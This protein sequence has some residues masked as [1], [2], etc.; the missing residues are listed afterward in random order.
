MFTGAAARIKSAFCGSGNEFGRRMAARVLAQVLK[1][2]RQRA[3]A[4]GQR[5][6]P[7]MD[8]IEDR[9]VLAHHL[10]FEFGYRAQKRRGRSVV[11]F[12]LARRHDREH[13]RLSRTWQTEWRHR[14]EPAPLDGAALIE[15]VGAEDSDAILDRLAFRV[16]PLEI[17]Q[18]RMI[19]PFDFVVRIVL[20][21]GH[22]VQRLDVLHVGRV[23]TNHPRIGRRDLRK[24][25]RGHHEFGVGIR[26]VRDLEAWMLTVVREH[27]AVFFANGKFE[28][29]RGGRRRIADLGR[30][31]Y[32]IA[33]VAPMMKGAS[34]RIALNVADRE[35]RADMRAVCAH[36]ARLAAYASIRDHAPIEEIDAENFPLR[37]LARKTNRE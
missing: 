34:D 35:I 13:L 11:A 15:N 28:Q 4:F 5:T 19:G 3:I 36:H 21:E 24:R 25:R 31:A 30:D 12:A 14:A 18:H 1:K 16:A 23:A 33:V 37:N 26:K 32:A 20:L 2:S 22:A 7:K 6:G 9:N 27:D 29:T 8:R 10:D 17:V